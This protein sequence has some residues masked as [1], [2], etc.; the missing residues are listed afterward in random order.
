MVVSAQR[1]AQAVVETVHHEVPEELQHLRDHD[2]GDAKQQR[3]RPAQRRQEVLTQQ[4][5][6]TLDTWS[7]SIHQG[8]MVNQVKLSTYT[9]ISGDLCDGCDRFGSE[10][11][12]ELEEIVT[13]DLVKGLRRGA[14]K[15]AGLTGA[16]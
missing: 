9:G 11:D 15:V 10:V 7:S 14:N 12:V 1:L 6:V 4:L 3:H 8:G 16:I 5:R 2:E 13:G